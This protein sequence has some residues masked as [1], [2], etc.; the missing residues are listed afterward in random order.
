M[1]I[2][3]TDDK[4]WI[5]FGGYDDSGTINWIEMQG[6]QYHW[7]V[8][9]PKVMLDNTEVSMTAD[10]VILDSGTSLSYLPVK[11]YNKILQVIEQ[12]TECFEYEA[13]PGFIFC[14]C[15]SASDSVFPTIQIRLGGQY[16]F[17]FTPAM[18]NYYVSRFAYLPDFS[19]IQGMKSQDVFWS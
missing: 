8:P 5:E 3:G 16:I 15:Q 13:Y 12:R 10:E 18:Y 14:D 6:T 2:G 4:S 19:T 9:M 17:E 1:E 11:D 7:T